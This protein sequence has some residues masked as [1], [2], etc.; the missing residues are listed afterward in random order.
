MRSFIAFEDA[1]ATVLES[2][3]P[4]GTESVSMPAARGRT[5]REPITSPGD[6]PPFDNA[7]MDGY[8]VRAADVPENGTT[9]PIAFSTESGVALPSLPPQSCARITTGHP[10]P[11]GADAVVR[12]ERTERNN[13][14]DPD[15]IRFTTVP[16]EGQNVRPAGEDI[17]AGDVVLESGT[18]IGPAEAS[19]LASVGRTDFTV[20]V[21]PRVLVLATG[22]ELVGADQEPGPGQ[23]RDANGPSLALRV[24]SAGGQ[25]CLRRGP[26]DASALETILAD[27][28][29]STDLLLIS[30][31]MSV[32]HDDLVL[33]VLDRMGLDL[34]FWKVRQRPGKP[35]AF[36]TLD[37]RPVLGLP[38]NPVAA[39]VCFEVYARPALAT[40]LGRSEILPTL[41]TAVLDEGYR[42]KEGY[43]YLTRGVARVDDT[44]RLRVRTTGHQGSG[45]STSMRDANCL[46]HLDED[47]VD[48]EPGR[49][50]AI[51]WLSD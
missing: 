45:I 9:L 22:S 42:V 14:G 17:A 43:H 15:R 6:V 1:R 25:P 26:D 20:A 24:E 51:Q 31:G 49:L 4:L 11:P 13:D 3:E 48:P 2:I 39:A 46:I 29:P 28:L 40:L 19:L 44:G 10:L 27:A 23:I 8:A 7:A 21:P 35:V 37:G 30:G 34:R 5:L 12:K 32:G 47:V 36:G 41:D 16:A 18:V 50:V 38:G 33:Q